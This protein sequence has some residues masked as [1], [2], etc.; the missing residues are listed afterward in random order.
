MPPKNRESS[1]E[2]KA[3]SPEHQGEIMK[4][5]ASTPE[6]KRVKRQ[7][8]TGADSSKSRAQAGPST[9]TSGRTSTHTNCSRT[10]HSRAI[11]ERCGTTKEWADE[12]EREAK[13]V[14]SEGC[15]RRDVDEVFDQLRPR[16]QA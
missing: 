16:N 12:H 11:T 1:P 9:A 2:R 6:P 4:V 13:L 8:A 5:E 3:P 14:I 7:I 15:I 10:G